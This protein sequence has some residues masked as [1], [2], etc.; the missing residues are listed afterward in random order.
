MDDEPPAFAYLGHFVKNPSDVALLTAEDFLDGMDVCDMVG[1]PDEGSFQALRDPLILR[2]RAQLVHG[3]NGDGE[4]MESIQMQ[5]H[6]EGVLALA[7]RDFG[8]LQE[9]IKSN[10]STVTGDVLRSLGPVCE[11]CGYQHNDW[12]ECRAFLETVERQ[13]LYLGYVN[14]D[15]GDIFVAAA[16]YDGSIE[17]V[18]AIAALAGERPQ[19]LMQIPAGVLFN[20]RLTEDGQSESVPLFAFYYQG[21]EWLDDLK[22]LLRRYTQKE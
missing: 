12:Q 8:R 17:Q 6:P 5:P 10:A 14:G 3:T 7:G 2:F 19:I 1:Q 15:P 20:L 13:A 4:E 22:S 9:R 11:K 21:D 16:P 18:T